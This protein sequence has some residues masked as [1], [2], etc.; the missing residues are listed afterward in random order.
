VNVGV[1]VSDAD[2]VNVVVG[3]CVGVN[4]G[5]CDGVED[6]DKLNVGEEVVVGVKVHVKE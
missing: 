2:G 3:V 6:G 1:G 4:D 5:V